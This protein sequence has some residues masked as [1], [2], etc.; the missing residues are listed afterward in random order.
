[1]PKIVPPVSEALFECDNCGRRYNQ[2]VM[3]EEAVQEGFP[4]QVLCSYPISPAAP[5]GG[6]YETLKAKADLDKKNKAATA[7]AT[8][9]DKKKEADAAAA[10]ADRKKREAEAA[11]EEAKT[12]KAEADAAAKD[13]AAAK[14][15]QATP[16]KPATVVPPVVPLAPP[17]P[18]PPVV[19]AP[20][21]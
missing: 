7:A 18:A 17:P 11:Q 10:V 19:T 16:S 13:A 14:T 9:E 20:K 6:C 5:T 21:A 3:K 12:K 2:S 8:A 4:V 15:A 1:M